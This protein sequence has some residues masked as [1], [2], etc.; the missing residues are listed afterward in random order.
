MV[1]WTDNY[2]KVIP[3]EEIETTDRQPVFELGR[4]GNESAAQPVHP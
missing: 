3:N 2:C 4:W 1:E